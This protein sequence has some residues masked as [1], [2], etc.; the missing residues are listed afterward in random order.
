MSSKQG[1]V[2]LPRPRGRPSEY[3]PA[4]CEQVVEIAQEGAGL[5]EIAYRIGITRDTLNEW[6]KTY[7][8]FSDA[9]TRALDAS[10]AWWEAQGRAGTWSK[11]FNANAYRL[12]VTN[13]FRKDWSDRQEVDHRA[14]DGPIAQIYLPD[15]G[16]STTKDPEDP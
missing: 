3:D 11:D 4:F 2:K 9:M 15:N 14:P 13:R 1:P 6:R 8:D 7:P 16:R 12:Q 10:H 5:A